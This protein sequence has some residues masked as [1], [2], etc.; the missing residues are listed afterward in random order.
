MVSNPGAIPVTIPPDVTV[1][2]AGLLLVHMPP[3][4]PS[5]RVVLLPTHTL[6]VPAIGTGDELTVTTVAVA[7]PL[8]SE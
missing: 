8:P 6:G 3:A 4:V 2:F 1:A 7:Q 5:L